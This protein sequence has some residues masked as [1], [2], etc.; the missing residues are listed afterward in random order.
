MAEDRRGD[1]V[2]GRRGCRCRYESF[3]PQ[4]GEYDSLLPVGEIS[5]EVIKSVFWECAEKSSSPSESEHNE[6]TTNARMSRSDLRL[7]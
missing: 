7:R 6:I 4:A 5:P 1:I 3:V 2:E